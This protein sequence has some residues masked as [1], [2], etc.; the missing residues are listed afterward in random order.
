MVGFGVGVCVLEDSLL[1]RVAL[2]DFN[3]QEMKV[4]DEI[5]PVLT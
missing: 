1:L 2:G 3:Y 4:N 5:C